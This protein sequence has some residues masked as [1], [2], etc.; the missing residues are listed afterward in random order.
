MLLAIVCRNPEV[1][2]VKTR[3]IPALGAEGARALYRAFLQDLQMRFAH[4]PH[5]LIWAYTPEGGHLAP[6]LVT[7]R[8]V[9]QEGP[10]SPIVFC[11]CS[12]GLSSRGLV[13]R[14]S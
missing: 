4:G 8:Q 14:W 12:N 13:E 9:A 6:S 11:A 5:A 7:G 10:H 2:A 3:L 1:G